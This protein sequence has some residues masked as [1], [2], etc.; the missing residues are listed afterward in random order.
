MWGIAIK[1]M[2]KKEIMNTY[3]FSMQRAFA[4]LASL[5]QASHHGDKD[6]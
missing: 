3:E 6:L 2:L 1:T 4:I 5:R